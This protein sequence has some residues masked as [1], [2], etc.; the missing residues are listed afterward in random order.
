M[1][2]ALLLL[3]Q[4]ASWPQYRGPLGSGLSTSATPPVEWSETR[5]VHWKVP[6]PGEGASTPAVWNGRVFVTTAVE[7]GTAKRYRFDVLCLDLADGKLLWRKTAVEEPVHE[8]KHETNS[9]ASPSP[10]TD[11]KRLIVSFGSRGLFAFD[12]DGKELWKRDLGDMRIKVGFGEGASP[13]LAGDAVLVIWDHEGASF[14]ACLDAGTG[15]ERWRR[16]RDQGTTWTTPLVVDG[17]VVVNGPK[18]TQSYALA[19]GKDLWSCGGQAMNPIALPVARDG[20][21]YCMTGYKGYAVRAIRLDSKGDVTSDAKQVVWTRDDAGPYVASPLL[22]DGLLYFTKERRAELLCVDAATG[23]LRYGP[24]ELADMDMVYASI[25]G[26]DGKVYVTGRSGRTYVIKHGPRFEVLAVNTLAE[27]ID[28]SP[29]FVGSQLLLRGRKH[30]Y[31]LR[32]Q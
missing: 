17:Q 9:Y 2:T 4:D 1:L 15:E 20:I 27:S 24:Q 16:P 14:L 30:L 11:G 5:N 28:A 6:L 8:G 3:L 22:Y 32:R 21:V 13:V 29:V 12:L 10:T 31:S 25:G 19:D 18:L 7:T 23:E 26:A